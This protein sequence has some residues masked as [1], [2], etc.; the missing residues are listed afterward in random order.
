MTGRGWHPILLKRLINY[1]HGCRH[2]IFWRPD[3]ARCGR[4]RRSSAL[5]TRQAGMKI[6]L[7]IPIFSSLGQFCLNIL[8]L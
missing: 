1:A 5:S 4:V 8:T 2:L 3:A 6:W 7:D